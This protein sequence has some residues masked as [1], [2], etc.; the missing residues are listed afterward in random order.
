MELRNFINQYIER[1]S[2]IILLYTPKLTSAVLVLVAAFAISIITRRIILAT[3][4]R[5]KLT[6]QKMEV[7]KLIGNA[8]SSA[9]LIFGVASAL[10][11]LGVNVSALVAGL[12]LSGFALGFALRDA[13]SNLLS[14]V[15]IILYQP[16]K[17]GDLIVVTG[18]EGEV[19]EIN[20]RYTVLSSGE[21]KFMIPNASIF[22][23]T[24]TLKRKK[25]EG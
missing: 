5:K 13:L 4:L 24:V 3:A 14:G 7:T 25:Q 17:V 1:F 21:N 16:F 15:L 11:T 6:G 10:G 19:V 2:E 9:I 12:G 22:N 18:F 23:N 8:S 20:L